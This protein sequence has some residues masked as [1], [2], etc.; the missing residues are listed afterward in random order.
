[1]RIVII[2][3]TVWLLA[4][5]GL[6][7]QDTA[8]VL[9]Y[10]QFIDIV[11]EHHPVALQGDLL[12]D[13]ARQQLVKA[14]GGFDPKLEGSWLQKEFDGKQYYAL[15]DAGLK[16]PTWTGIDLKV[17]Y[18]YSSG[19]RVNEQNILP[20]GGLAGVGLSVP[21]LEGLWVDERRVALKQAKIMGNLSQ[22]QR[23][24]LLNDLFLEATVAYWNWA[25]REQQVNIY[26]DAQDFA[27]DQFRF[28][29]ESAIYGDKPAIDTVEA[30]IQYQNIQILL[31]EA[32]MMLQNARL[33]LGNFLW[34]EGVV[35]LELDDNTLS[36]NPDVAG[37][38][39]MLEDLTAQIEELNLTHPELLALDMEIDQLDLERKLKVNNLLPTL[40]VNYNAL[41][42]E[43]FNYANN[44]DNPL[45]WNNYKWGLQVSIPIFYGKERGELNLAKLKVR[46]TQ[47]KLQL[48]AYQQQNKARSYLNEVLTYQQQLDVY[49][50]MVVNYET[51]LSGEVNLFRN[52]ESSQFLVN[53]RQMKLIEAR[54]KLVNAQ[55]KLNQKMA[56]LWWSLGAL[57]P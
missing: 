42:T 52:G 31:M 53:S 44:N 34:L 56:G 21:L 13:M 12:T 22:V 29:K 18:E 19:I 26:Q 35:P 46:N 28:V 48:K 43:R 7:A 24:A 55:V 6:L 20:A 38:T 1:M 25:Y 15:G 45:L 9:T 5:N 54:E 11:A 33:N 27:S 39:L 2:T 17:S 49:R 37:E 40:N 32:E 16:I 36:E 10:A 57:A 47:L 4:L 3:I 30:L 41:A 23:Q 14:R 51:L 50:N 8:R